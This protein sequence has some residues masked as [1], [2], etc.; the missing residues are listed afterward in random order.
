MTTKCGQSGDC[1]SS[2]A[3]NPQFMLF[4]SVR[5]KTH[6]AGGRMTRLVKKWPKVFFLRRDLAKLGLPTFRTEEQKGRVHSVFLA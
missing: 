2:R 3:L 4:Y 5:L 6:S 1:Q